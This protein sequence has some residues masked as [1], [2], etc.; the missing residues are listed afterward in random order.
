MDDVVLKVGVI[1]VEVEYVILGEEAH[2]VDSIALFGFRPGA[3]VGYPDGF[4]L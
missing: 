3:F 1:G 4:A 2:R